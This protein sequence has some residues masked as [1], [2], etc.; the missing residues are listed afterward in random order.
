[1]ERV[2]GKET[3]ICSGYLL[4]GGFAAGGGFSG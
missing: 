3:A 1:V 2:Y 4:D